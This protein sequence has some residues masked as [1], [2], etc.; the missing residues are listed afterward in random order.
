LVPEA[1]LYIFSSEVAIKP[2]SVKAKCPQLESCQ[3]R[4]MSRS[5]GGDEFE[6]TNKFLA[7]LL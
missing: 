5:G 2:E 3:T 4:T 7:D 1:D 6:V